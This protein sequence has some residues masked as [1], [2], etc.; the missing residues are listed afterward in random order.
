[1]PDLE[2]TI[3]EFRDVLKK[4]YSEKGIFSPEPNSGKEREL[5]EQWKKGKNKLAQE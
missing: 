5:F 2:I 4:E 3:E 1:M